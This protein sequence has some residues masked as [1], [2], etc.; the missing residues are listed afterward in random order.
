MK[1]RIEIQNR[2][3]EIDLNQP[4]DIS[5]PMNALGNTASAWYV[6]QARIEPVVM[7]DWIGSVKKGASVNFNNIL[8]NPHGNGTHTECI[9][10]ITKEFHSINQV[11]KRFFFTAELISV[12]PEQVGE[13][14]VISKNQIES[15]IADKNPEALVIRTLPNHESK[16]TR[17][18]SNTNPAYISEDAAHYIREKGIKHLLIDTPSVDRENDEGKLL[19][20][21]AF[22]NY[23]G[24]RRIDSTITEFVYVPDEIKDES[25]ILNL[26]IASFEND[27]S[28]SKPVL[29]RIRHKK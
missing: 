19:A 28:P 13:D 17:N 11:L 22:W 29:Y 25:Y 21:K 6:D 16:R 4:I 20:H 1:A 2:V 24:E 7:G 12:E 5:L 10:H 18:Y 15:R 9:G 26:Q 8:F 3:V 23:H 27:A 14:R